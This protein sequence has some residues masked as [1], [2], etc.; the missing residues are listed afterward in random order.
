MTRTIR[1]V[2]AVL[3]VGVTSLSGQTQRQPAG[4][5][6]PADLVLLNGRIY[7][8]SGTPSVNIDYTGQAVGPVTLGATD[9]VYRVN[10]TVGGY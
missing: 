9:T 4:D 6:G 7:T 2:A 1:L 3:A 5:S 8:F 10:W